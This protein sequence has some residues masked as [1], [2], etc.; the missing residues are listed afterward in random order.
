MEEDGLHVVDAQ[1]EWYS[2]LPSHVL[3]SLSLN[4]KRIRNGSDEIICNPACEEISDDSIFE[5]VEEILST[6]MLT[7]KLRKIEDANRSKFGPRSLAKKWEDRKQS[8]YDYFEHEDYDP[9]YF[10]VGKGR[11]R[12]VTVQQVANN[13]LKASSA[14]LPYMRRKGLVLKDA[15]D[16]YVNEKGVYPCVLF[17]RTQEDWKTRNVWGYPISDTIHEQTVFIPFLEHEKTL[18]YRSALL[19][20]EFVDAAITKL[21]HNKSESDIVLCVDF[22]AYDASVGPKNA[23]EAFSYIASQFQIGSQH[24][25]YD[26]FRRFVTIPIY[27]PD[28]LLTGP[29]GVPSGS[30]FTNTVDSLVQFYSSGTV[31]PC[32][33]QGDDGVY[34]IPRSDHDF[35]LERF[36]AAGL[37]VNEDKSDVFESQEAIY[38]QRY[39]HP[40]YRAET[41]GLGGVYSL[42]RAMARIK[43]LERWTDFKSMEIEGADFFALRTITILENC[44]HHP[45]F[46]KFVKYVQSLDK[47]NLEFS[48]AGLLAFSRAMESK[49][50]AGVFNQY[51][52]QRGIDKFETM[53]ILKTIV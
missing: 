27:T 28:G 50:R 47:F 6:C 23:F 35:I 11:L 5:R 25:V 8:L 32:Q 40:S 44:K 18:E 51:G 53:K 49:S 13:L 26:L 21:L 36:K 43:Y 46:E 30:S 52:L 14:G 41:G 7:P 24:Q 45:G 42:Y 16:S 38:L 10:K 17:T 2:K 22:S 29:H 4:N 39:Y 9:L 15:V 3:N 19:G 33:I 34:V 12:P 1:P 37:K 20:P 48:Q 31:F